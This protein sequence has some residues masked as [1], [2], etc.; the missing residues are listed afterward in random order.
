MRPF[1]SQG[2]STR[3]LVSTETK[4]DL[5]V[6]KATTKAERQN[7][8]RVR[9]AD[10]VRETASEDALTNEEKKQYYYNVSSSA[11]VPRASCVRIDVLYCSLLIIKN[12]RECQVHHLL[13]VI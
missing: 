8:R 2:S 11:D 5:G 12:E 13:Y 4:D 7:P 3:S 1:F 9:F 10:E 6:A